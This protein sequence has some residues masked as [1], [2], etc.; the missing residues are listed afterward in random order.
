M[1]SRLRGDQNDSDDHSTAEEDEE[2]VD[3]FADLEAAE[4]VER[5]KD[6][7]H[8]R[9]QRRQNCCFGVIACLGIC[10]FIYHTVALQT[11]KIFFRGDYVNVIPD[12][13]YVRPQKPGRIHF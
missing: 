9:R 12:H 11:W 7:F 4:T 2:T 3:E 13:R 5:W 10:I 1:F 6:K 8:N